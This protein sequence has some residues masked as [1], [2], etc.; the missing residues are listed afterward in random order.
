MNRRRLLRQ[1]VL[2][3]AVSAS[4][5]MQTAYAAKAKAMYPVP[6]GWPKPNL[7]EAVSMRDGVSLAT[8]VWLPN[9]TT[10]VPAILVR[11]CYP[12]RD[13]GVTTE[14][15]RQFRQAGYAVV[16][17]FVRGQWG[18][19]GVFRFG[20]NEWHDGYD[21]V[22][23]VA[24]QTWCDSNVGMLGQSYL[25]MTQ[26]YAAAG[27]PPHL[28]AISPIAPLTNMFEFSPFIGGAFNRR[29]MLGWTRLVQQDFPDLVAQGGFS[30]PAVLRDI[31]RRLRHRPAY[32]AADDWLNGAYLEMYKGFLDHPFSDDEFWNQIN[33]SDDAYAHMD[34][35]M[36]WVCGH[37]D[38]TSH[39]LDAWDKVDRLAPP[40]SHHMLLGPY[41]HGPEEELGLKT[42]TYGPYEFA[43]NVLTDNVA[44]R[45]PFFD[46]HV[47]G[48]DV[49]ADLPDRV[50]VYI[51]G[52]NVWRDFQNMPAPETKYRALFLASHGMAQTDSGDGS[53]SF[54]VGSSADHD[55]VLVDPLNPVSTMD[56]M[57]MA[58]VI[59][60]E[61]VLVYTSDRLKDAVTVVGQPEVIVHVACDTPDSD[62]VVD[63][64]EVRADGLSVRLSYKV[65][66]L[67]YRESYSQPK[68]MTP[69][70]VEKVVLKLDW[71]GHTLVEGSRLQIAIRGT[72]FTYADPNPNTGTPTKS[73]TNL[74]R[75]RIHIFHTEAMPSR[76]NLP[77]IEV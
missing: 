48:I 39:C 44:M 29:H 66:R 38:G 69:G 51:T 77:T 45:V 46:R 4:G 55:S 7:R 68:P 24:A 23:W 76:I 40:N 50:R 53:A 33:F 57:N 74:Q 54:E 61:D 64:N 13:F 19:E 71:V 72:D 41:T 3:S 60:R 20:A 70:K 10:P 43:E 35:P 8:D 62:L 11:T 49:D 34:V 30:N 56:S 28:K 73:A 52:S 63:L 26:L 9:S 58:T 36:F 59:T 12:Y 15:F 17:Q 21:S 27:A 6:E 32:D 65:L 1:S 31:Q 16:V 47:K 67:R 22:E 14:I 37:F 18:S 25:A 5:I 42:T 2:L 75:T